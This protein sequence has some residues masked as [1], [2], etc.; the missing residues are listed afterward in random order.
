MTALLEAMR[1]RQ[2]IKNLILFAPLLFARQLNDFGAAARAVAAASVF[3]LL[4]GAVYL[5]NDLRDLESDRLHPAK[6]RRPL[7]SGRL[8]AR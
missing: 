8:G 5:F 2:W 4:S 3:C 7:A 6:S 1:P